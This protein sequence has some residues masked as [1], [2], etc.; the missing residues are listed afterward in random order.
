M[1]VIKTYEEKKKELE[2]IVKK[3]PVP[4]VN[5]V[6]EDPSS[7]IKWRSSTIRAEKTITGPFRAL[8]INPYGYSEGKVTKK[9]DARKMAEIFLRFDEDK[10]DNL[11]EETE[12]E[13][14]ALSE[15]KAILQNQSSQIKDDAPFTIVNFDFP[16]E[17]EDLDHDGNWIQTVVQ[18]IRKYGSDILF[19]VPPKSAITAESVIDYQLSAFEK[20]LTLEHPIYVSGY[21]P[22][23][24]PLESI[25]LIETYLECGINA[26]IYD[27]RNRRLNDTSL[28]HLIAIASEQEKPPFIHG[29]HVTPNR[30]AS[31]YDSLLDLSLPSFGIQTISN[32]RRTGGGSSKKDEKVKI[33]TRLF[34]SI[35]CIHGYYYP[36]YGQYKSKQF[37]C[38]HCSLNEIDQAFNGLVKARYS[39]QV[40]KFNAEISFEEMM[41][42]K[43]RIKEKSFRAYINDKPGI[44]SLDTT[45]ANFENLL[46][47]EKSR[48]KEITAGMS[49]W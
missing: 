18:L 47:T 33:D 13:N 36:K 20:N 2:K 17:S 22:F 29:L 24:H 41:N 27:F 16:T 32:L 45:L 30:K 38:P 42:I 8:Q 11:I 28:T 23:I 15:Q 21:V 49:E 39:E 25:K 37:Q 34:R 10:V 40:T 14:D 35:R 46:K 31:P 48:I 5:V 19:L 7:E 3:S 6:E 43:S 12:E 9:A 26:I 4:I 1:G 44:L